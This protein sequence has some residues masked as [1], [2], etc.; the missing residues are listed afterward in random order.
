MFLRTR[1]PL[2]FLPV[3]PLLGWRRS[4]PILL[5][6]LLVVCEEGRPAHH[7]PS[8]PAAAAAAAAPRSSAAGLKVLLLQLHV[9][10]LLGEGW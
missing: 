6:V 2:L 7:L 9:W 1:A 3:W 8:P 5:L 4:H 10:V